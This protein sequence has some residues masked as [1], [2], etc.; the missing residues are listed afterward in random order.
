L[1]DEGRTIAL[2][3]ITKYKPARVVAQ[4]ASTGEDTAKVVA[5]DKSEEAKAALDNAEG[6]TKIGTVATA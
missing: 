6:V 1:R 2:G 5:G 4:S 3:I